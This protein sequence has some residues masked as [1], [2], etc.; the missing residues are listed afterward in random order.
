MTLSK[1]MVLKL[2]VADNHVIKYTPPDEFKPMKTTKLNWREKRKLGCL[3]VGAETVDP[4]TLTKEY[5]GLFN[6]VGMLPK[7]YLCRFMVSPSAA[8]PT[9]TPLFATHFR[10]GDCLDVRAK[11]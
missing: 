9:G 1:Y 6:S 3:L 4:S 5:C 2:Q 11:T 8:L 7:K 10:V